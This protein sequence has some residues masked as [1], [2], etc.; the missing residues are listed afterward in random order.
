MPNPRFLRNLVKVGLPIP[1]FPGIL[2]NLGFDFRKNEGTWELLRSSKV[3]NLVKV[4]LECG[5]IN[6]GKPQVTKPRK[7]QV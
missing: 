7:Y 6:L 2:V 1:R 4:G 3:E 5:K